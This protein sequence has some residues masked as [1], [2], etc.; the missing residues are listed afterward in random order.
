MTQK[1]ALIGVGS[2]GSH[3]ARQWGRIPGAELAAILDRNSDASRDFADQFGCRA[4]GPDDFD[5]ML[6]EAQPDIV[7]VCVPTPA[8]RGYVEKAAEAGKAVFVEKPLARTMADCQALIDLVARTGISLMPG[9][10]LRYFPQ[11]AAAKRM[12]DSGAVGNPAAIRTARMAGMPRANVEGNWYGDPA[13]SGG[14]VLDMIIHDFDWLRWT[15]GPVSRVFAKGL[16]TDPKSHGIRD[17]ALVTLRFES[18]AMAHVTGSWAHPGGFSTTLEVAGDGGLIEYD[19]AT[20]SPLTIAK[21]AKA[22]AP[23]PVAIPESPA[24]ADQDPY[25]LELNAFA[26]A[27]REG[28]PPPITV[29]DAAEAVR[30]ALAA[31]ESIETGKVVTLS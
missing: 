13:Q 20:S 28:T 10:V 30:I 31:L 19:S 16:Y 12:V 9:H 3:H 8:H 24:P 29:Q 4:Y 17:Y 11:Y 25:Y 26:T 14:V 15:F 6:A 27:L 23:P 21:Q 1:V 2:M 5:K 18:G 7:D 22:G